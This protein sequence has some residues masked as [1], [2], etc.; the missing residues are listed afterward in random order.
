M[1]LNYRGVPYTLEPPT[2]EMVDSGIYG[3]YRGALWHG[4]FVRQIPVPQTVFI[5]WYRGIPTG[6]QAPEDKTLPVMPK[7]TMSEQKHEVM[8]IHLDNIRRSAEHRLQVAQISGDQQLV[9]A[10]ELELISFSG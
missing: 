4:G 5:G 8:Q 3:K 10:I 1:Q 2:L 7:L 9:H 6:L